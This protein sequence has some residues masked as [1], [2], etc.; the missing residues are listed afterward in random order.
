[1][2]VF[3]VDLD[4]TLIYSYKHIDS[5]QYASGQWI[6]AETYQGREISFIS[7]KTQELLMELKKHVLIV[8]TTTRTVE[9]YGRIDLGIGE[10]SYA[11]TC[12]GGVLLHMGREDHDWYR[13]SLS[14][15]KESQAELKK[16][17]AY[18]WH[19]ESRVFEVRIIQELFV[20]T[21]CTNPEAVVSRLQKLLDGTLTE[22]FHNGEKV[23]AV[24]KNLNK[25]NALLRF[26]DFIEAERM[27]AAGDSI[28]D[29]PMLHQ[30]DLAAAPAGFYAPDTPLEQ[31][32]HLM[33]G[34]KL[35][36]EEL[37]EFMLIQSSFG[38]S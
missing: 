2:I 9:Q 34:K 14:M 5:R 11:L 19:E 1:M 28:F 30:A 35:F 21:K 12:N 37:L 16:A 13:Q 32:I 24:P 10:I 22:V 8:P 29:Q 38:F 17:A 7:R 26:R 31:H 25:G 6:L 33:S 20:F 36:S 15:V 27:L 3:C 23:Y 4:N 18:L